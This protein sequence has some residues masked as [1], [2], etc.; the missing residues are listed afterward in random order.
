MCGYHS[1]PYGAEST[2]LADLNN[3]RPTK[4]AAYVRNLV[5]LNKYV[6]VRALNDTTVQ[7]SESSH[8][9]FWAWGKAGVVQTMRQTQAYQEDWLGL[10]TLDSQVCPFLA[11]TRF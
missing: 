9:G 6:M 4:N 10:K 7:P 1:Q 5:S 11:L 2:Y 3:E 8:H